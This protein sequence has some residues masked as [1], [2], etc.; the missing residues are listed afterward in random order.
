MS[1][2]DSA[3]YRLCKAAA[4]WLQKVQNCKYV[5]VE[6]ITYGSEN[7]DVWG[8]TG[9]DSHIVEVKTSRRD[10]L[11]DRKKEC[12]QPGK[13]IGTYRYY[14]LPEGAFTI[15]EIPEQ[16]GVL[17]HNGDK[18]TSILRHPVCFS[19]AIN[20]ELAI[21]CSIMRREGIKKQIFNYR[22]KRAGIRPIEQ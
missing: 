16:W 8:T 3:H 10:F 5:A 11:N 6:L 7:P 17:T 18:I 1:K 20:E 9:W 2:T 14:L 13:G 21:L 19:K 12:R 15:D 4:A 22:E